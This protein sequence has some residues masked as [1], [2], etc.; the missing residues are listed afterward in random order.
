MEKLFDLNQISKL[1]SPKTY[2]EGQ[3]SQAQFWDNEYVANQLLQVHLNPNDD[4]ASRKPETIRATV[5]WLLKELQ[6]TKGQQLI[7]FGCGPGLYCEQFAQ[8]GLQVSGV[9][10]SKNSIRY[11]REHAAENNLL[12]EYFYQDYLTVDFEEKFDAAVMIYCDFGVLSDEDRS[13][14]LKNIY[15]S[16]KPGGAFAFDVFTKHFHGMTHEG[17]DWNIY[18]DKGFFLPVPHFELTQAVHYPDAHLHLTQYFLIEESRN[19]QVINMWERYYTLESITSLLE[20]HGFSVQ[21]CMGNLAGTPL[22]SDAEILG[23]VA[24]K[25]A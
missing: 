13:I 16:L 11:A 22:T 19:T 1:S 15:R 5:N 24:R 10:Y 17:K 3:K 2:F 20:E 14:M 9:D 25:P 6:L 21:T 7:D 8:A 23:I 12:I 18:P 4:L